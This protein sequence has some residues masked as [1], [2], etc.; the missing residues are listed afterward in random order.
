MN[1]FI[2]QYPVKQYFGKGCAQKAVKKVGDCGQEGSF[3]LRWW[4]GD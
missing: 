1:T 3:G 4:F 2:Y